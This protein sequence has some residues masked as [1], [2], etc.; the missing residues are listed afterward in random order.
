M[1]SNNHIQAYSDYVKSNPNGVT[2]NTNTSN[3]A[4]LFYQS[5]MDSTGALAKVFENI[6]LQYYYE[7]LISEE[8]ITEFRPHRE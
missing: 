2:A 6:A 1:R 5:K 4:N 8:L 7:Y 3:G